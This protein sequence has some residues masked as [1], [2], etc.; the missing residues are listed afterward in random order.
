[1]DGKT[2][3]V[4]PAIDLDSLVHERV[5]LAILTALGAHGRLSFK[6]LKSFTDTTDGNLSTHTARLEGAGYIAAVKG[7][8]GRRSQTNYEITADGRKALN[9]YLEKLQTLMGELRPNQD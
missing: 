8:L 9:E 5:R 2:R 1:M 3:Q 7:L 4:S 6:E